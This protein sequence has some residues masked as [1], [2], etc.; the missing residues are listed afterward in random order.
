[1]STDDLELRALRIARQW[2]S[3]PPEH[4]K[5]ALEALEPELQRAHVER[6]ARLQQRKFLFGLGAGFILAIG[7]LTGGVLVGLSGQSWLAALLIGPSLLALVKVFVM[8]RADNQDARA[9][10][11]IAG[12]AIA[13]PGAGS[14]APAAGPGGEP[15]L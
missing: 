14:G 13:N 12:A 6:M 11:R 9:A 4:L 10:A 15:P 1:M 7:M 2:T 8:N 3:V 5:Q